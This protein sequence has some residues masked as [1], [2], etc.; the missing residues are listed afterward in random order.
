MAPLYTCGFAT[1]C[2]VGHAALRLKSRNLGFAAGVYGVLLI[3]YFTITAAFSDNN[4]ATKE[5]VVDMVVGVWILTGWLGGTVHTLILRS[6]VFRPRTR[7]HI[8]SAVWSHS[9][10]PPPP[11]H[12]PPASPPP[13]RPSSASSSPYRPST[14]PPP[15]YQAHAAPAQ[16]PPV[17]RSV[18]TPSWN[19]M[20][21][22][23]V[24]HPFNRIGPYPL[25]RK[26]GEGGQGAVYL[27]HGPDGQPVAIK[28]LHNRIIGG[29]AE[30]ESF[31]REATM[32]RRVRPFATAKVI[33]VG[34][35]D[36]LAYIVSEYVPGPS[37]ERLVRTEGPRG[38][39]GLT[40]LAIGTAAAL[41]GIHAAGI[42][43]RDFKPANV[44]IGQDGP[45]VIDFGIARALDQ[46]TMTSGGLKGTLIYM[47]PE[48]ISGEPVGPASDIFSWGA[49]ML[50]GATGRHAFGAASQPAV[51][52]MIVS[53]HPDL[54]V[55]PVALQ[56]PVAA[57][58]AK[59]PR[60]RPTAA[61]VMLE[62]TN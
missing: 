23:S 34:V 55:L 17:S 12:A 45:R 7:P 40:R 27:A 43:H 29:A 6:A 24:S 33:D 60:D 53:H 44:L 16:A 51:F 22:E 8:P 61:E 3:V 18:S 11:H 25:I 41:K 35:V 47:S 19:S 14:A 50:F 2:I 62:V 37:L 42:V 52:K 58:L 38:G 36:D 48:Q 13:Y 56:A 31:I 28:V 57:C 10:V 54:S 4:P 59:D 39:D 1:P 20:G 32:A 30:R 15:S 9:P 49:T 26:I 46:I 21:G 5:P